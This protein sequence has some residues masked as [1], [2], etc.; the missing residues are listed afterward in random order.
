MKIKEKISYI[1][2][3]TNFKLNSSLQQFYQKLTQKKTN[4]NHDYNGLVKPKTTTVKALDQKTRSL[5]FV[6]N[7]HPDLPIK[8]SGNLILDT[9]SKIFS[10][11]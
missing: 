2:N 10:E 4:I 11:L 3:F 7:L 9:L 8:T 1:K 5:Q 6:A